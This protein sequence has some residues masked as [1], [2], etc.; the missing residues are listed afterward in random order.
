M[1]PPEPLQR[2]ASV[3]GA[4]T[5]LGHAVVNHCASW[6]LPEW[7]E[8]WKGAAPRTLLAKLAVGK[9]IEEVN[10][11][12]CAATPH[13][14]S[15]SVWWG[16]PQGDYDFS[17]AT[18]TAILYLYGD[19]P[20]K[21]YPETVEHLLHVLLMEEGGRPRPMVPNSFG[22]VLDTENHHL[23]TE[24]SRYLKNQ[25]LGAH[26]N[27]DG[28]YDNRKN[29]LERWLREYLEE[30]L[31]EGL[32][33]FNSLPYIGF[34][35]HALLNLA[36]FADS[37]EI[38][39]PAR[40]LLDVANWQ[41]ALGSLDLRRC[42]PFRRQTERAGE[43][44]LSADLHT[45]MMRVWASPAYAPGEPE[46]EPGGSA[47]HALIAAL[48]PYRLPDVVRSVCLEKQAEYCVRYGRGPKATPEIYSAGP[49]YL[50]SAGGVCR[51][52]R[53]MIV[54]RPITLMLGD[55]LRDLR[56]CIHIPGRGNF[57]R[58]N[59]TG[60]YRDFACA[61]A[62]VQVPGEFEAAAEGKGWRIFRMNTL[63][64]LT[65]AVYSLDDLGLIALFPN[66]A[67]SPE[68][69]LADLQRCNPSVKRL[70]RSFTFPDGDTITYDP[71]APKGLWVIESING[72]PLGR[73][74]DS[75]SQ[76]EWLSGTARPSVLMPTELD[77]AEPGS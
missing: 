52:R 19:T 51:G 45:A 54:P 27:R 46:P 34:T 24:G 1:L 57:R 32:Y 20:E 14:R 77:Q 4:H 33:E 35:L 39:A 16:H 7:R 13:R 44:S 55:G 66:S 63:E 28:R 75:W 18:L 25:W 71:R 41:Y 67:V 76:I 48:I 31:R 49:G 15:G 11:Y 62:P 47:D 69:L 64:N 43:T 61:D 9:D 73:D 36:A 40:R 38:S 6:N 58:W 3:P 12:L 10:R 37:E 59:N 72:S 17:E 42:A 30:M 21:L 65:V 8:G 50:L 70:T 5:A 56:Q 2:D 22:L 68:A 74:Y 29:G 60:V 23:M 26:G 53:S